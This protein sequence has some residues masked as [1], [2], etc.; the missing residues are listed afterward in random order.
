MIEQN[1]LPVMG[2]GGEPM[3]KS[4][5]FLLTHLGGIRVHEEALFQALLE[6]PCGEQNEKTGQ[7]F[8]F[9]CFRHSTA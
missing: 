2:E 9:F 7:W 8:F 4:A 5:S 3:K 6:A 1:N